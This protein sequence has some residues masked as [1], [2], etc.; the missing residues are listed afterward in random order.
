MD[1]ISATKL[2]AH[3]EV[4]WRAIQREFGGSLIYIP[5]AE[6]RTEK[7]LDRNRRLYAEKL[8]GMSVAQ[9]AQR[10]GLSRNR[11]YKILAK[12]GEGLS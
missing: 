5:V 4:H 9:L 3:L 2:P 12:M 7:V 11:V 1:S 6:T 10:H 8:S